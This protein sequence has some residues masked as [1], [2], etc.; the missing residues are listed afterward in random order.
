MKILVL[1]GSG[2]VGSRFLELK[3]V[4]FDL[5]SPI[6]SEF[7]L[8]EFDSYRENITQINPEVVINFAAFT[9]V[10]QAEEEKDNPDG[11]VYKLN[12][13]SPKNLAEAAR[14]LGVHFIH[15]STDYVFDG[16]KTKPY[17]E[18][19]VTNPLSWYAKTKDLGEKEVLNS[20]SDY[21]IVR[22]EM[23]FSAK[24][25]KKKDL[26]RI[27]LDL[28][29][30]GKEISATN[31]QKVTPT[32]VDDGIEAISRL[33]AGKVKGIYHVASTNHTTPFDFARILAKEFGLNE[34]LVQGLS[35]EEFSKTRPAKRPKDSWLSVEKFEHEIGKKILNT[36]EDSI[37]EFKKQSE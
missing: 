15:L 13:L 36:V 30:E 22:I 28:L 29:R 31:D 10:D 8:L 26:A 19:D 14:E 9:N 32:F 3:S 5:V 27:F 23:P 33:A 12:V 20:G 24:F 21:T 11:V 1:G 18:D 34:D 7:D 4:E 16:T 25:D 6:H 37:G 17:L 2:L 35:F